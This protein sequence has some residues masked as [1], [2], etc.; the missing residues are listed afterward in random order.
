KG[1]GQ[2]P[3]GAPLRRRGAER[4]EG[5][6]GVFSPDRREVSMRGRVQRPRGGIA[7]ALAE[8]APQRTLGEAEGDAAKPRQGA[9]LGPRS[10]RQSNSGSASAAVTQTRTR[11][12]RLSLERPFDDPR[13][14]RAP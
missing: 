7:A 9:A 1:R 14:R 3:A 2:R 11:S 10:D 4:S 6:S 12:S 13:L 5:Q 8:R